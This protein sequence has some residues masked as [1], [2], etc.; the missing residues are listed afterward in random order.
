MTTADTAPR[1]GAPWHFWL[2]AAISLFWNAFGGYDYTMSHLQ[3]DAYY[4]ASGMTEAQIG[5]MHAYPVWMHAV[6]ALG[7][8]GS[9]LGS[10]LLLLR[11]RWA[12]HAFVVSSLGA[13]GSLAYTQLNGG[14]AMGLSP[15]FPLVI[16]AICV[17]FV[18]F[19]MTM[20]K[21]GVLR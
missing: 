5:F 2:V 18:W 21:Q 19:S 10:V 13:A 3:G 15:V 20:T 16:L 8:W 6:W 1:A 11:S 7:V 9:V 17:F 12:F 4:K 14:A